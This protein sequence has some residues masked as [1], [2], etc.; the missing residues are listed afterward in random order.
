MVKKRLEWK[1]PCPIC[2]WEMEYCS[3][4]SIWAFWGFCENCWYEDP[5]DFYETSQWNYE[6]ITKK[7]A[8]DK[9]LVRLCSNCGEIMYPH[10]F[11]KEELCLFCINQ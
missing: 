2:K 3:D 1:E 7:E 6:L 8:L 9:G 10:E 5:R 11:N 4:E